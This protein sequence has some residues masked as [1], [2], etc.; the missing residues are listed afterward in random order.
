MTTRTSID[1]TQPQPGIRYE[2]RENG[3]A[4]L[5]LDRPERG[6]SLAPGMQPI[7]RAIWGE[8]RDDPAV[9]REIGHVFNTITNGIRNMPSYASQ[10]PVDDRW[11]IVS[12][13]KALQRSQNATLA[14][15]PPAE[16][17]N[18]Q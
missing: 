6:N 14:D 13:V 1:L 4:I 8:V 9:S 18:L 5:T 17:G 12:Y 10:I 15:V 7:L 11:A 16:R 3:I 2:R